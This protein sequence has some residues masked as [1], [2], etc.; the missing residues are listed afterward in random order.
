MNTRAP[1]SS[2]LAVSHPDLAHVII[3]RL[4]TV[5]KNRKD[6]ALSRARRERG[7]FIHNL[8]VKQARGPENQLPMLITRD[9]APK[10]FR[11]TLRILH[12]QLNPP[13]DFD[14]LT[15]C[16][17]ETRVCRPIRYVLE[18]RREEGKKWTFDIEVKADTER[19]CQTSKDLEKRTPCDNV[20]LKSFRHEQW[21]VTDKLTARLSECGIFL[22][23]SYESQNFTSE[24][25]CFG[26]LEICKYHGYFSQYFITLFLNC[27]FFM[28]KESRV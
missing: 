18:R 9:F 27:T 28:W 12:V 17:I 6:T 16:D 20:T 10:L 15:F 5:D 14:L 8:L 7:C 11:E 23:I 4:I 1:R 2:S 25:K 19:A 24:E 3:N 13:T 26:N 21:T 22:S